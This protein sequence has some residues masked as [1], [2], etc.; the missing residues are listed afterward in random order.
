MPF[1]GVKSQFYLE[2]KKMKVEQCEMYILL[3][4][5]LLAIRNQYLRHRQLGLTRF[6]AKNGQNVENK[7]NIF[8][9]I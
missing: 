2:E 9:K 8:S 3:L 1:S 6:I 7:K 5:M 4:G